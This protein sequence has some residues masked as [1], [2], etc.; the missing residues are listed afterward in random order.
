MDYLTFV[1]KHHE[2]TKK[3]G[4][5]DGVQVG[6]KEKRGKHCHYQ[7]L[8]IQCIQSYPPYMDAISSFHITHAVLMNRFFKISSPYTYTTHHTT[9]FNTIP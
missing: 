7:Q 3:S 1:G 9:P 5:P 8:L 4:R 2:L 6:D